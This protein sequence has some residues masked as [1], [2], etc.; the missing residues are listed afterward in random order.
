MPCCLAAA[1]ICVAATA[2]VAIILRHDVDEARSIALAAKYPSAGT[3]QEQVGCTLIDPRWAVTAAHTMESNPPFI[4]YYVKFGGE[5]YEVEKIILHPARVRDAVDSANDIALLKL[6]KPVAGIIPALLYEKDDEVGKLITLVGIGKTGTG[7]TGP[8]GEKVKVAR[9]A[10][11][12]VEATFENS[13]VLTFD[14][15]PGGT[16]LEG[17]GGPGDSGGP[18]FYEAGGKLYLMGVSSFNSGDPADKS[19]GSYHT[20]DG[21]CRIS[22][23]RRW[24]QDTI[25]A[26]P[27]DTLW[28]PLKKLKDDGGWPDAAK[29]RARAFFRAWNS[30]QE[31]MIAR[32]YAEHRPP[33]TQGLTPEARAKGWQ[34]LQDTYGQYR[35]YGYS[36]Q[37]AYRLGVLVYAERAKM[38]RGVIFELEESKPHRVKS[39][40]MWDASAPA[41]R[42]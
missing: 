33:S 32:F 36:Q 16:A 8:V 40:T 42:M 27:P 15:P 5:R 18:M 37:G 28:S 23:K 13:L 25:A 26:D 14:A 21:M 20:L 41:E 31:A 1:I 11:N 9:A 6:K 22:T 29:R 38:W 34:E 17:I 12:R 39:M 3:L 35:P 7:L 4:N 10:T 19:D 30:G 2:A 24:I